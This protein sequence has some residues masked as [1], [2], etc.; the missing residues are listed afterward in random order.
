ME[1]AHLLQARG[2][3]QRE[4]KVLDAVRIMRPEDVLAN[5]VRGQYGRGRRATARSVGYRQDHTSIRSPTP[6]RSRHQGLIDHWRWEALP[7]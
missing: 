2:D 7:I 1:A 5:T 4:A 6:R 3:P